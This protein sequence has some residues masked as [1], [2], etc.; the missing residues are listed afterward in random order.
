MQFFFYCRDKAGAFETRKGLLKAHWA[1]MRPYIDS[2]IARGPTMSADGKTVTGSLHIVDLP[3]AEA[4]RVFAHDD[5]LA[6]GGVFEDIMMQRFHNVAG[7]TMWQFAGDAKN[8]RF[9][10]IAEAAPGSAGQGRDLLAAQ[11][12]YLEHADRAG[13]VIVHGPLLGDDGVTWTG[14]AILLENADVAAAEALWRGDPMSS[15]GLYAKTALYPW[16]FGGEENLQDL[17]KRT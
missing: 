6:K 16:R 5:P 9:M 15:A 10:C 8:A 2:M 3:D 14:T 4:A 7:R 11:R 17:V 13:H 12:H 1:F